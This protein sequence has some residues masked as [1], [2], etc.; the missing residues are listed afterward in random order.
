MTDADKDIAM[1][2]RM[3]NIAKKSGFSRP[4]TGQQGLYADNGHEITPNLWDANCPA[5]R[6]FY[7]QAIKGI[8][9]AN[10]KK[11]K[12]GRYTPEAYTASKR[13]KPKSLVRH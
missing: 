7:D 8:E 11:M 1:G 13:P 2:Q 4:Q 9:E 3:S 5:T 12:I 10:H 6:E